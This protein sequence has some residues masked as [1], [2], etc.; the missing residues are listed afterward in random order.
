[1]SRFGAWDGAV[2]EFESFW[3]AGCVKDCGAHS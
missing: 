2:L 1:L 3:T